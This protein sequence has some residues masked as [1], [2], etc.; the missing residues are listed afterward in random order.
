M[1]L[2]VPYPSGGKISSSSWSTLQAMAEL[3]LDNNQLTGSL[4]A[5]W[6]AWGNNTDNSLQL[7]ITNAS[8]HGRMPRQWVE[9]FC[10]AVVKSGK[11]R[12][13]F[14]PIIIDLYGSGTM[15]PESAITPPRSKVGPLIELPAQH[16]SINVTL[17]SKTYTFDYNNPDSVC[18]I[19]HAVRNTI[20]LWGIF[21]ALL[22]AT[23]MCVCLWQRRKPKPATQGGWFSHWRVAMVL[24][25][26]KVRLSRRVAKYVWFLV[27]DVGWTIYSQVTDAITIHQVVA[28]KQMVYAY[29]L[30]AILLVP[31]V[32][33]FILV[34]RVS[35]KRCQDKVGCRTL[36]HRAA[37]PVIGLLLAPILF[38]GLEIVLIVHGIGVPLP[39]WW[40]S[41]N[42]H[43]GTLYRMQSVAE[44]FL[45]AL[46]QSV[47]Q[48]KLYLMGIDPNGVHVYID[49]PPVSS[50]YDC[51]TVCTLE[52]CCFDCH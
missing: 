7:S 1:P 42:V 28:S 24:S 32:F 49:T 44:A 45:S 33:M 27:S 18:G 14:E 38:F 11:A 13:L 20:L 17:A 50:F 31:F 40:G 23:L 6:S 43:L 3:R 26:D 9:Q 39:A 37:G 15:E 5:S 35:I 52:D 10:L 47:V 51:F 21:A 41:L 12:V 22:M 25:H 46:P 16:A 19:P 2:L 48:T 4:P 34:V 30:L 36:M 29:I 8:L